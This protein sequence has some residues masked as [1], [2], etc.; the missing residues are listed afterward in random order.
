M[1]VVCYTLQIGTKSIYHLSKFIVRGDIVRLPEDVRINV[2][3][4]FNSVKFKV[5]SLYALWTRRVSPI[6]H[7]YEG[8]QSVCWCLSEEFRIRIGK[9][10]QDLRI[11]LATRGCQGKNAAV[12]D[13]CHFLT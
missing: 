3:K 1:C 13:A 12:Q 10:I 9:L 8:T 11:I 7:L 5:L 4:G 6:H 2:D